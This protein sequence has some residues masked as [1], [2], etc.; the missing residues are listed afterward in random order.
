MKKLKF[1][2]KLAIAAVSVFLVMFI[3]FG[4][5]FSI[6]GKPTVEPLRQSEEVLAE[7]SD[8]APAPEPE[9][10]ESEGAEEYP[11]MGEAEYLA[12]MD[13]V[14]VEWQ[15]FERDFDILYNLSPRDAYAASRH[16]G[17]SVLRYELYQRVEAL[18]LDLLINYKAPEV[19]SDVYWDEVHDMGRMLTILDFMNSNQLDSIEQIELYYEEVERARKL[20]REVYTRHGM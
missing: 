17:I 2:T 15:A 11:R 13:E 6:N 9:P 18:Q 19:Y 14:L 1:E 16:E 8:E 4:T 10:E 7:E 20:F 3:F 5:Y 12:L